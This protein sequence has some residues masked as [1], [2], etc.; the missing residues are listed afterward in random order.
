M[1]LLMADENFVSAL[2]QGDVWGVSYFLDSRG[3]LHTLLGDCDP[4]L[5]AVRHHQHQV[6]GLLLGR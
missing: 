3:G 5:V 2:E 6:L 1:L 4:L